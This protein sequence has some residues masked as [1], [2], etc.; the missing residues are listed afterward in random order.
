MSTTHTT[1]DGVTTV[2]LEDGSKLVYGR[3]ASPLETGM[4]V[5][6]DPGTLPEGW[7]ATGTV[8]SLDDDPETGEYCATVRFGPGHV[9]SI[10]VGDLALA[11]YD[12]SRYSADGETEA[13]DWAETREEMLAVV[14]AFTS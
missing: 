13:Q 11:G 7:A 6:A 5:E 8:E 1:P 3:C 10:P 14:A 9:Q 4:L 12:W 2:W